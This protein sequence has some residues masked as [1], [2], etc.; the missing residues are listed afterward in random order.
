[1]LWC[2]RRWEDIPTRRCG[3]TQRR[4]GTGRE[5]AVRV[6]GREGTA[7]K[8]GSRVRCPPGSVAQRVWWDDYPF[9]SEKGQAHRVTGPC[10]LLEMVIF[11]NCA[12][13]CLRK[14]TWKWALGG[15]VSAR[16]PG[17]QSTWLW[18]NGWKLAPGEKSPPGPQMS[19]PES[20]G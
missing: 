4:V 15:G 2:W 7:C 12:E 8:I 14:A 6:Q 10:A 18:A 11:Y 20:P 1:M 3:H 5:D 9:W 13:W 19:V 17:V 16:S